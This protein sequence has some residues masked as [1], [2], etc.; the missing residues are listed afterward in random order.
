VLRRTV[1]IAAQS[2]QS[3]VE[4]IEFLTGSNRPIAVVHRL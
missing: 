3:H 4:K 2:G 1:E